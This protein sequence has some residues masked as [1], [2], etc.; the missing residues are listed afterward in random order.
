MRF[1]QTGKSDARAV[2]VK[3]TVLAVIIKY[4]AISCG[5]ILSNAVYAAHLV[6]DHY[7]LLQVNGGVSKEEVF[8]QIDSALE[9]LVKQKKA[10]AGPVAI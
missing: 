10:T 8:A 3:V 5:M 6:E 1:Y 4:C 9:K 7:L 2:V